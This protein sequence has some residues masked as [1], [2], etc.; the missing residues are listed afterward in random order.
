MIFFHEKITFFIIGGAVAFI[1][2]IVGM[3]LVDRK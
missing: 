2:G 3:Q 1:V